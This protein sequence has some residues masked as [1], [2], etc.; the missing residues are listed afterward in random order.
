MADDDV[1]DVWNG[2]TELEA[3][4]TPGKLLPA[5]RPP[6]YSTPKV[7]VLAKFAGSFE[8]RVCY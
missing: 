2:R 8:H 7:D 5:Y 3:D 6:N 1:D 4:R